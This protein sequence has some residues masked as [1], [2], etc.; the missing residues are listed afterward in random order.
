MWQRCQVATIVSGDPSDFPQLCSRSRFPPPAKLTAT[1]G[2]RSIFFFGTHSPHRGQKKKHHIS[3]CFSQTPHR[4]NIEYCLQPPRSEKRSTTSPECF[5]TTPQVRKRSTTSPIVFHKHHID[6]ILNIVYNPPGQKKK[7]HIARMFFTTPQV[8]KRSTASPE[9]FLRPPRSEKEA[10]H[11]PNVSVLR[12]PKSEK[13]A[14]HRS[15][16]FLRPPRSERYH[17]IARMLFTTPQVR[18]RST[19]LPECFL[20]LPRSEKKK[21]VCFSPNPHHFLPPYAFAPRHL[22]KGLGCCLCS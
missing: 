14:P 18:K 21:A 6:R 13:E 9:C 7:H 22:Y 15:N 8:R 19:T 16:V 4:P 2:L 11:R 10:P 1:R 12:P 5:F 3:D 20:Q 17:H